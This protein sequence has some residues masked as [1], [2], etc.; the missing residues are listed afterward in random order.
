MAAEVAAVEAT[1]PTLSSCN[2][3]NDTQTNVL[4]SSHP[5]QKRKIVSETLLDYFHPH[6]PPEG[7]KALSLQSLQERAKTPCVQSLQER[8]KT[9]RVQSL[10]EREKTPC[11]QSPQEREK[12]PC[13]KSDI[14]VGGRLRRFLAQWE[15]QGAHRSILSLSENAQTCPGCPALPAV[16]QAPTKCLVDLYSRPAAQRRYRSCAHSKQLRI[17]QSAVPG[18]KTRQSLEASYRLKFT[19]QVPDHTKVQD[20]DPRIDM[21]LSQKRRMGYLYRSHRRI[22]ACTYPYPLSKISQVPPQRRHLPVCQSTL[23]SGYSSSSFHQPCQGGKTTGTTTRNQ[24]TPI[25]GRLVNP[26][27]LQGGAKVPLT[28]T[29]TTQ[30][31][32][33]LRLCSKPQ[34][35]RTP[36]LPEVRLP[37]I[38]FFTGLGFWEAHA[39]QM[40][41]TS[42]NVSSPLEEVCYQ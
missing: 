41:K 24:T 23:W 37:R 33:R 25:P 30:S 13:T 42:G 36:S 26:C 8:E 4:A 34:E 20:G 12:T 16:M 2:L 35:V 38:P 5:G 28:N 31:G 17:L 3:L 6:T 21:G 15:H 10:Q 11:V 32:E 39:R 1:R 27:P 7:E 19:K 40:E 18:P 29:S 9:P 22:P 14:P